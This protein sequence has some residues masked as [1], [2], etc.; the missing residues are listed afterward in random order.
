MNKPLI[1]IIILLILTNFF[2]FK[3]SITLESIYL[4]RS[5]RITETIHNN[6]FDVA[7]YGKGTVVLPDDEYIEREVEK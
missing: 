6:Q 7:N 1:T 4:E 3:I 2:L 5:F